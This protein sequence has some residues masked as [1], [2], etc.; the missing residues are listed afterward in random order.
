MF[1]KGRN[2][3]MFEGILIVNKTIIMKHLSKAPGYNHESI[4]IK[5]T[6]NVCFISKISDVQIEICHHKFILIKYDLRYFNKK[7]HIPQN[8]CSIELILKTE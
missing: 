1:D 2:P 7:L 6:V 3:S 8:I 5:S 4:K